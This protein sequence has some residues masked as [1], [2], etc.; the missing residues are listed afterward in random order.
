M[1]TCK[2]VTEAASTYLD[3]PRSLPQRLG[4]QLHLLMCHRC[5]RFVRQLK[6]AVG[7]SQTLNTPTTPDDDAI[8]ATLSRIKTPPEA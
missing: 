1:I 4:F 3:E 6:I 8:E 2:Q 7:A 5:R